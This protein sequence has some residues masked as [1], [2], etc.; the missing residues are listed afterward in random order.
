MQAEPPR[1][2]A[3]KWQKHYYRG[4]DIEGRA[5]IADHQPK[6]KVKTFRTGPAA[7]PPQAT[8]PVPAC[9]VSAAPAR[10]SAEAERRIAKLE[11]DL[12]KRDWM[13][14][15]HGAAARGQ[16]PAH[17]TI[18]R[19]AGIDRQTCSSNSTTPSLGRSSSAAC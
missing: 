18:L 13:L 9:P 16:S 6:L 12:A 11:A 2:P 14:D 3:D 19:R 7:P 10:P 5:H 4:V 8:R 15:D 17:A 1:N